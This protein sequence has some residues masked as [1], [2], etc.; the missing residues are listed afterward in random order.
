MSICLIDAEAM[1]SIIPLA[2]QHSLTQTLL[3][4][5]HMQNRKTVPQNG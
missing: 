3:G 1:R 5:E 4:T 2:P